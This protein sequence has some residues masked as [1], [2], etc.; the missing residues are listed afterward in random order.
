[1]ALPLPKKIEMEFG[2]KWHDGEV[3]QTV[4]GN[5][6]HMANRLP[7][8]FDEGRAREIT[9]ICDR[10]AA[11]AASVEEP[12]LGAIVAGLAELTDPNDH[13]ERERRLQELDMLVAEW[14]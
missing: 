9:E 12:R 13:E 6:V 8:A 3:L 10:L 1:M 11:F 5:L 14:V 4:Q 2:F 7:G